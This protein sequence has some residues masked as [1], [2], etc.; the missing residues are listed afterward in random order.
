MTSTPTTFAELV[1]FAIGFINILITFLFA[2]AF[3]VLVW[4]MVDA[5]VIHAADASKREEGRSVAI[6][7]ALVMVVM[8]SIWG[9]LAI[10]RNSL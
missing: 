5:W 2:L 4:K 10:L 1:D 9:I 8:L 3:L 7:S 6:T